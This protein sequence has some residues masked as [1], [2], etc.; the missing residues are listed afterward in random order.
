MPV[1]IGNLP[2]DQPAPTGLCQ[3][4]RGVLGSSV[5]V[6]NTVPVQPIYDQPGGSPMR[7]SI[8]PARAGWW[9]IHAGSIWNQLDGGWQYWH[10]G[11]RLVPLDALGQGDDRNH[12]C[13]HPAL[14][15]CESIINTAYRLNANTAYYA[16]MF[17]PCA[18]NG[19]TQQYATAPEWLY[20]LGEFVEDGSL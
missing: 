6:N 7:I 16:E 5:N 2:S 9:L 11:V 18:S 19:Y 14:G 20:I 1:N 12:H 10:S 4:K 13:Q 15:Y 3:I 8:T 17:W